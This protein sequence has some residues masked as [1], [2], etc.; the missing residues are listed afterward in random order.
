MIQLVIQFDEKNGGIQL[1]GPIDNKILC[2]GMIE[3][4]KVAIMNYKPNTS[5]IVNPGVGEVAA[6]DES[7]II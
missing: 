2:L 1:A 4:A 5:G 7:K 3:L 6:V